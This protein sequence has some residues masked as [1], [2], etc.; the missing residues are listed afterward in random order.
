MQGLTDR[1]DQTARAGWLGC[2][3]LLLPTAAWLCLFLMSGIPVCCDAKGYLSM[4][5]GH[6]RDGLFH[7][8]GTVGYRAYLFPYLFSWIP[9]DHSATLFGGVRGYSFAA[10]TVFLLTELVVLRGL[11]RSRLFWPTYLGFFANPLLLI[12]VPYPLQESFLV[13]ALVALTPWLLSLD[14]AKPGGQLPVA[15]GLFLAVLYM[16]RPSNL[17]LAIP[18]GW[19]M[20][21]HLRALPGLAARTRASLLFAALVAL[22]VLPQSAVN[23]RYH[24]SPMPYSATGALSFQLLSGTGYAKYTTNLSRR[25]NV[26]QPMVYWNPLNCY[27]ELSTQ[28]REYRAF[29]CSLLSE[30]RRGGIA[31]TVF[32]SL[33]HI[34]NSLSYD[35]LKPYVTNVTLPL[36]SLSQMLSVSVAFLGG[37]AAIRKLILR[38]ATPQDVFL[39]LLAGVTLAVTTITAVETR[40]GLLATGAFSWLSAELVLQE[41]LD[42]KEWIAVGFGL[43]SVV[44]VSALLSVYVLALSGATSP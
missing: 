9:I 7:F 36:F 37:F 12:Y 33:L 22:V 20:L 39:M 13:L 42:T 31:A 34:F 4:I 43:A 23:L 17:V 8:H 1:I 2:M 10:G 14:P 29:L 15:S 26:A 40:F 38:T 27:S 5:E 3:L 35:T 41:K 30:N 21:T 28:P 18:I 24:N 32:T 44:L 16:S 25:P 11:R 19:L 6:Q